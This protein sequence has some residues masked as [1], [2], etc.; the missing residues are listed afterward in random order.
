M[1]TNEYKAVAWEYSHGREGCAHVGTGVSFNNSPK[2]AIAEAKERAY[3]SL[4]EQEAEADDS[5]TPILACLIVW[6]RGKAII[7]TT[8]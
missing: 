2:E 4:L 8:Y 5:G 3:N 6:K 7:N 1:D